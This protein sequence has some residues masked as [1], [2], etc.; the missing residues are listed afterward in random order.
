MA[1]CGM[2]VNVRLK[3]RYFIRFRGLFFFTLE[4]V[5][6]GNMSNFQEEADT[7]S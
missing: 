4:D 1:D 5:K 6:V 3:S 7:R 2:K